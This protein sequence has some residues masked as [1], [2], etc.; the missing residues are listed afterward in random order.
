[1]KEERSIGVTISGLLMLIVGLLIFLLSS[2]GSL[3]GLP[4]AIYF[5]FTRLTLIPILSHVPALT[6]I[7]WFIAGCNVLRIKNW[8]RVLII[9]Y[10][11]FLSIISLIVIT[12]FM[13]A[14]ISSGMRFYETE[15]GGV[16]MI[17][18]FIFLMISSIFIIFFTRFKVKEQFKQRFTV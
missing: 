18:A 17:V 10:S 3:I 15:I 6:G 2:P 7:V 9:Y 5:M 1:M 11:I 8:A 13:V 14:M 16:F 4:A 12:W